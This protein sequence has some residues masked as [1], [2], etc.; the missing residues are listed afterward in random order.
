MYRFFWWQSCAFWLDEIPLTHTNGKKKSQNL[1]FYPDDDY[2]RYVELCEEQSRN[3]KQVRQRSPIDSEV[4]FTDVADTNVLASHTA[5]VTVGVG[6]TTQHQSP[7]MTTRST[8]KNV[9]RSTRESKKE[10]QTT[11]SAAHSSSLPLSPLDPSETDTSLQR[12]KV[13]I[14]LS[15]EDSLVPVREI[16]EYMKLRASMFPSVRVLHFPGHTHAQ[17]L[18]PGFQKAREDIRDLIYWAENENVP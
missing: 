5:A 4:L 8:K 9:Q 10:K 1:L 2:K 17:F 7:Q 3:P 16:L 13:G 18:L 11:L 15:G 6:T 14:V 12:I